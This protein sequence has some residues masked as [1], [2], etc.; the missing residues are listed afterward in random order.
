MDNTD[1]VR[2]CIKEIGSG[3]MHSILHAAVAIARAFAELD[4]YERH[5]LPG[6]GAPDVDDCI[7]KLLMGAMRENT[8]AIL[9][10]QSRM[11]QTLDEVTELLGEP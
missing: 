7:R 9:R 11:K 3:K 8:K 2:A 1:L 4:D 10:D 6:G 5:G